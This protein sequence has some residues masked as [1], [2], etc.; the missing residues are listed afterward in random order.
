MSKEVVS[1]WMRKYIYLKTVCWKVRRRRESRDKR[2]RVRRR[3]SKERW[4]LFLIGEWENEVKEQ[5][6][7]RQ[8]ETSER[9]MSVFYLRCRFSVSIPLS[10]R[11]LMVLEIWW[12]WWR[13]DSGDEIWWWGLKRYGLRFGDEVILLKY[14]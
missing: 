9:K 14:P 5:V 8:W 4:T 2:R 6:K 11:R 10:C 1:V 13:G 7:L 3:E 12:W